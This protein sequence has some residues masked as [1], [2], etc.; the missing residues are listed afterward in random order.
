MG[1]IVSAAPVVS[2]SQ[3]APPPTQRGNTS[4]VAI[5]GIAEPIAPQSGFYVDPFGPN[6]NPPSLPREESTTTEPPSI[7]PPEP[8]QPAEQPPITLPQE[9]TDTFKHDAASIL[10]RMPD[11]S[12]M[13]KDLEKSGCLLPELNVQPQ[14]MADTSPLAALQPQRLKDKGTYFG[15]PSTKAAQPLLAEI[16]LA[17]SEAIHHEHESKEIPLFVFAALIGFLQSLQGIVQAIYFIKITYPSYERDIMIG[18]VNTTDVNTS[19][20]KAIIICVLAVI[21]GIISLFI[22]IKRARNSSFL[23]YF[24]IGMIILNFISQNILGGKEFISGN[25]LALPQMIS[26]IISKQ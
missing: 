9:Q 2:P 6:Q 24:L 12:Q 15:S 5:E 14:E 17:H 4:S 21:G 10:S 23:L 25:P 11:I 8:L 26:E 19:V 18:L 7:T 13:M 22:L 3:P 16:K 20:I 1:N